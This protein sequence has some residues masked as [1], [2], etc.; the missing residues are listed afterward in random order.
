MASKAAGLAG[1]QL[2]RL[3]QRSEARDAPGDLAELEA[4]AGDH[5]VVIITVF[6][7]AAY[8]RWSISLSAKAIT[9]LFS[10]LTK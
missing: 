6:A 5:A 7:F 8:L 10:I 2:K 1:G 9:R 3:L 4:G